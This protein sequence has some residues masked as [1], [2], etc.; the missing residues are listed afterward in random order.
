MYDHFWSQ[1]I[2]DVST[3][4]SALTIKYLCKVSSDMSWNAQTSSLVWHA[5]WMQG[6]IG[7]YG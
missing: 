5:V 2:G 6:R 1:L 7:I 3:E 4:M